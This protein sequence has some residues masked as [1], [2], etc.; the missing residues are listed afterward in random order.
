MENETREV[1]YISISLILLAMVL[2]FISFGL[3]MTHKISQARNEQVTANEKIQEYREF[4]A[5]NAQ[6][7]I[8]DEAI[9]LIRDKYDTGITVFVDYRKNTSTGSTVGATTAA[10]NPETAK[11][12]KTTCSSCTSKSGDHRIFNYDEYLTHLDGSSDLNYFLLAYNST[13]KTK[14]DMRNWFPTTAK[15][16]CYLIYNAE[17]PVEYY[18]N[19][20]TRYKSLLG[21]STYG[22]SNEGKLAALDAAATQGSAID[23]ISGVCLVSYETLGIS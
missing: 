22:T 2:S 10:T 3:N 19:L 8:G 18:Y 16:R 21:T 4:N 6:T 9:E 1:V 20:M 7:I 13:S 23:T 14:D 17:D 12:S 15:Y 11:T 5:Y